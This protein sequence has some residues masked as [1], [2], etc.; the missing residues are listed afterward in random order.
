MP[1]VLWQVRR[2]PQ[3]LSVATD[4]YKRLD[5]FGTLGAYTGGANEM[6]SECTPYVPSLMSVPQDSR[7][8]EQVREDSLDLKAPETTKVRKGACTC[9]RTCQRAIGLSAGPS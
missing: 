3:H 2:Y 9:A 7:S 6:G 4:Y 8:M 1:R 5:A